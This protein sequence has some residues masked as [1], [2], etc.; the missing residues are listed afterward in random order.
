MHNCRRIKELIFGRMEGTN[1]QEGKTS[2]GMAGQH[3]RMG[4][5]V[6][7]GAEP[8]SD[9]QKVLKEFGEDGVRYLQSLSHWC[10]MMMMMMMI[11][12]YSVQGKEA[13]CLD[14]EKS[15]LFNLI[16]IFCI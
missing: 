1:Q 14:I 13:R 3:H 15:D 4:Q 12:G 2:Q 9:G 7:S 10:L 6:A 8:S 16:F 11:E 5:G